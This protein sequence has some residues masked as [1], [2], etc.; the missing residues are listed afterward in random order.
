MPRTSKCRSSWSGLKRGISSHLVCVVTAINEYDN[1]F[2]EVVDTGPITS[3]QVTNT[4]KD[5]IEEVSCLITD[6]KY[7]HEKFAKDNNIKLEQVKSGTYINQNG[8]SLGNMN[9]LH[10]ELRTFYLAL[11]TFLLNIY[12]IF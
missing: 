8:Y 10:S 7:S 3:E 2:L 4:F 6:Y 5:R 1:C 12:N 9:S 11:K